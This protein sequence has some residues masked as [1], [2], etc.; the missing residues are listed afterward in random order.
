MSN[1]QIITISA[2]LINTQCI[3]QTAYTEK[4]QT[5]RVIVT[6]YNLVFQRWRP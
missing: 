3:N 2:M 5:K 6:M 1:Y 4:L